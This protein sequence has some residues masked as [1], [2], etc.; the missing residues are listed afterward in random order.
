MKYRW[1]SWFQPG[2][3][4]FGEVGK[5][6]D[7]L[8][9]DKQSHRA[10]PAIFGSRDIGKHALKYEAAYLMGRNSARAA[11]SFTMRVQYIF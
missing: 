4:A 3:Q 7:W 9:S 2:L 6:N 8:A 11:K 5:W 1:K 10:G